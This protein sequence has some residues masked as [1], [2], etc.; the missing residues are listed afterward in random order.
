MRRVEYPT[1]SK[2][3]TSKPV[4]E[5]L[6][7]T[8]LQRVLVFI[9]TYRLRYFLPVEKSSI[10]S[11]SLIPRWRNIS[12]KNIKSALKNIKFT[13]Q[14]EKFFSL[15]YLLNSSKKLILFV[16]WF[17][18]MDQNGLKTYPR[19]LS[20]RVSWFFGGGAR[21]TSCCRRFLHRDLKQRIYFAFH[22]RSRSSLFDL[23]RHLCVSC[24]GI[25]LIN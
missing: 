5:F 1:G 18:S 22:Y 17:L 24:H 20:S 7:D 6:Q 14:I 8:P 11:Y 12:L 13:F 2:L 15:Y 16:G 21:L 19:L 9:S 25:L 10:P 23:A 4:S 3:L